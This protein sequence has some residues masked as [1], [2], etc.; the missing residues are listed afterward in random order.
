ME[1]SKRLSITTALP[2]TLLAKTC[3]H[4]KRTAYQQYLRATLPAEPAT[5]ETN[6]ARLSFR[7]LDGRRITRRFHA[8]DQA[9]VMVT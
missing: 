1:T 4:Q 6:A 2:V 3:A 8:N 7:L 5:D 9:K